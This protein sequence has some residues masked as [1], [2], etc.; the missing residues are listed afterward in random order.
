M[1]NT[2]QF[3]LDRQTTLLKKT[4]NTKYI[5]QNYAKN[6][7]IIYFQEETTEDGFRDI[8]HQLSQFKKA[9]LIVPENNLQAVLEFLQELKHSVENARLTLKFYTAQHWKKITFHF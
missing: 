6:G 9:E 1:K 2:T 4:A 7:Q 5:V 8:I 3:V